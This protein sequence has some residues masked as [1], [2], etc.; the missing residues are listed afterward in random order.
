MILTKHARIGYVLLLMLTLGCGGG[1]GDGPTLVPVSGKVTV[2]GSEPFKKGVIRFIPT[3]PA[4]NVREATTDDQG[5]YVIMF[6]ARKRGLQPGDY[7][8]GFSLLQLPDG[9][10]TPQGEDPEEAGAV[11]FVPREY[12]IGSTK[13]LTTV[14]DDGGTFDFDIAGE[15]KPQPKTKAA[16]AARS[17]R[18]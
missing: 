18:S 1:G 14:P 9:S 6:N 17:G 15:L 10:P 13:N 4:L 12:G 7:N 11:E 16:G 2:D 8:V 3:D 5:N